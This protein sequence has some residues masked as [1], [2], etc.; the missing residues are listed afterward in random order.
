MTTNKHD[1]LTINYKFNQADLDAKLA[2]AIKA[3][4]FHY[5][6]KGGLPGAIAKFEAPT[7]NAAVKLYANKRIAGYQ[8][9]EVE[10]LFINAHNLETASQGWTD[11]FLLKPQVEIDA[12]L[13][14]IADRVT[15][16]YK[17]GLEVKYEAFLEALAER[18]LRKEEQ[19]E[20]D[21]IAGIAAKAAVKRGQRVA[22]LK[23][24]L[25][26]EFPA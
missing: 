3:Y 5:D 9:Y 19:V 26:E 25:A 6:G 23:K 22:A 1:N 20:L 15:A 18:E 13:K 4:S 12:D 17:A 2:P 14:I 7:L 8:E 24:E 10:T 11:I 21:R 16:E